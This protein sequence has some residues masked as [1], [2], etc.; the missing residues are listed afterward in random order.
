MPRSKFQPLLAVPG[1]QP[2][3][4]VRSPV[5]FHLQLA[6]FDHLATITADPDAAFDELR[7]SY[8]KDERLRVPAT[9]FNALLNRPEAI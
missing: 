3:P 4:H 2:F 5:P 9:V 6:F 8:E 7:E 1:C